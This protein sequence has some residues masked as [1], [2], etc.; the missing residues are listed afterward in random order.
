MISD[1]HVQKC[2]CYSS[3]IYLFHVFPCMFVKRSIG[4]K[5][6]MTLLANPNSMFVGSLCYMCWEVWGRV[7]EQV[8]KVVMAI[9][10]RVTTLQDVFGGNKP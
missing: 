2:K 9:L 8:R 1:L 5:P 4:F 6:T 10:G 3:F 7:G